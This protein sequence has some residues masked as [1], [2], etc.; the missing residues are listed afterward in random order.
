MPR[1]PGSLR[2][3]DPRSFRSLSSSNLRPEKRSTPPS[4]ELTAQSGCESAEL[5]LSHFSRHR[6]GGLEDERGPK[7]QRSR[8]PLKCRAALRS[9]QSCAGHI[10]RLALPVQH[11]AC[12]N[13][14][15]A[16]SSVDSTP[17]KPFAFLRTSQPLHRESSLLA[18]R[19]T[20][21]CTFPAGS[22]LL[23]GSTR[24]ASDL[25]LDRSA[26]M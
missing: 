17:D 11:R 20:R 10:S 21:E 26:R 14:A 24:R 7:A 8:P 3:E 4:A 9:S 2:L 5:W 23:S 1:V 13:S 16:G 15:P 25:V 18:L 6:K 19:T 12:L 22:P